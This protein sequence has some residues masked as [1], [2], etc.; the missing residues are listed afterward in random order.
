ML[1]VPAPTR[2]RVCTVQR[3]LLSRGV[4]EAYLGAE[5]TLSVHG[6]R[7]RSA[8]EGAEGRPVY[9]G[10]RGRGFDCQRVCTE[11]LGVRY[12]NVRHVSLM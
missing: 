11:F 6:H 4:V 8:M 3:S 9:S 12:V 5:K 1:Q 7:V 2:P 10:L